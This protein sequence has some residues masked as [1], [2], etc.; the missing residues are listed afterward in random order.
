[1]ITALLGTSYWY[2]STENICPVPLTYR[3]GAIDE[4]F[5]IT[6]AEARA[7]M[8]AA[9]AAWEEAIGRELFVY[10]E[11]SDFTVNFIF[12][13]RQAR[14]DDEVERSAALDALRAESISF[15]DQIEELEVTYESLASNYEDQVAAYEARL[16]AYNQTVSRYNDQGG[17]PTEA[18]EQL[19]QE[20]QDL[21]AEAAALAAGADELNEL[22]S[23]INDLGAEGNQLIAAYNRQ[24]AAFNRDFGY[25]REFTQGEY[26]GD[27]INIYKFSS[28]A[29]LNTV[30]AHELGHALGI[31]HVADDE[32]LM[33]YLLTDTREN[34]RLTDADIAAFQEACASEGSFTHELRQII[35]QIVNRF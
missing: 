19:Q 31:D 10:D 16:T 24:V 17:A 27:R 9:E 22:A 11:G 6:P 1:L 7:N 23:R 3:I 25:S 32:A 20:Q 34:P 18:F 13:D 29:E 15:F 21:N 30:L 33:Y 8:A 5:V 12:D 28:D 35:R 2:V 4:G 26:R 14:A